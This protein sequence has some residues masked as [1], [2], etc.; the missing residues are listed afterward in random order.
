MSIA[1]L[2]LDGGKATRFGGADKAFVSL[3]GRPLIEHVLERLRPQVSA[4]AISANGDPSRFAA[5][6]LPVL[7]DAPEFSACGPLAG[8]AAGLRWAAAQ[9]VEW[10]LTMPVDTPLFPLTLAADLSPGPSVAVYEGRQHHLAALWPVEF[11]PGLEDF[12]R[13]DVKYKVRDAL[14]LCG[15]RQ[16]DFTSPT[17]PFANL[18]SPQDLATVR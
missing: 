12:L 14:A 18:N 10:L 16:V 8:V 6:G 7:A 9:G 5:Y 15:A 13:R 11:L 4:M 3:H 17:D 1:A 2:I